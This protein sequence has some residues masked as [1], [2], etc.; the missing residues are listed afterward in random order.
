VSAVG[1]TSNSISAGAL[2]L[3]SS[4]I[5]NWFKYAA[6]AVN[7]PA[8]ATISAGAAGVAH[9]L[10]GYQ[11]ML[12]GDA[13]GNADTAT[14]S[15]LDGATVIIQNRLT[16]TAGASATGTSVSVTGLNIIGTAATSM[17]IVVTAVTGTHT[18]AVA[19]LFGY[20]VQ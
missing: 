9:V 1:D 11:A 2:S 17:S 4:P 5:P 3:C 18:F 15:V 12:Y 16:L 7:T 10:T 14:V 6:P 19:S 13:T 20:D 8:T